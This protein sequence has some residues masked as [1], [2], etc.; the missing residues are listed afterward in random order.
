MEDQ[1]ESIA[2]EQSELSG[3]REQL[4]EQRAAEGASEVERA[5][6]SAL[7]TDNDPVLKIPD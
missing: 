2:D 1:V 5:S 7:S 4:L 6:D 3:S